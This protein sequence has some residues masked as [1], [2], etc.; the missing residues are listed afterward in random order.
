[1]IV[2][3][4]LKYHYPGRAAEPALRGLSFSLKRGEKAALMGGNG[5]GKTTLLRCLNGLLHPEAGRVLV[6][7]MDT[8]DAEK[9]YEIRRRIGM[10]FQNPDNQIV[11]ATVIREIAFGL[12]NLG[13]PHTDI[14][15]RSEAA[16]TTFHLES[17]REYAPH[18]L[19]GGEKQRLALAAV[20]VLK[21]DFLVLDEPTSLLDPNGRREVLALLD[22]LPRR[23]GILFVTQ[24]P[25]E[26]LCMDR[27]MIMNRGKIVMDGPPAVVFSQPDR[28]R[29]LGLKPP[30]ELELVSYL[31]K[32]RASQNGGRSIEN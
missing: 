30:V 21:P 7:G 2:A 23:V 10:V 6:D 32:L 8:N 19:S 31:R 26:A 9:R 4:D 18:L 28:I 12:E 5:S 24:Y 25:E 20:W 22:S 1:M 15:R 3:E 14:V 27:L 16:L 11:A 29:R 17:Y 13:I